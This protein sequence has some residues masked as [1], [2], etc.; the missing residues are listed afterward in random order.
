MNRS[1]RR[2]SNLIHII[3]AVNHEWYATVLPYDMTTKVIINAVFVNLV[4]CIP[5]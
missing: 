4:I 2:D 5:N 1:R 3:L